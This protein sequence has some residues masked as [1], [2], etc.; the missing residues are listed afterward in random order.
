VQVVQFKWV[1]ASAAAVADQRPQ[2]TNRRL[3]I[4]CR[5]N[6]LRFLIDTGA[7]LSILPPNIKKAKELTPISY[8]Y[9]ANNSLIPVFGERI[10]ELNLGLRRPFVWNF[11][12]ADVDRPI[13]GIDFLSHYHL[14][15]DPFSR[16]LT[17]ADT[18]IKI[19]CQFENSSSSYISAIPP[20]HKFF[21]ILKS[22]PK[23][24]QTSDSLFLPPIT[25]N[26]RHHLITNCSPISFRPRRLSPTMLQIAKKEFQLLLQLGIV[27]P[28]SSPWASPLHMAAKSDGSYRAC[29]DYRSLNNQTLPDSYPIPHI[30]DFSSALNGCAIF[31]RIDLVRAYNQ[32][33]VAEE[34]VPKTAIITPFGL[35]EFVRMPLGLRNSSQTFQ[36]F[37][38]NML[39]DLPFVFV[40]LD[41]LLIASKSPSEHEKHLSIVLERL[42]EHGVTIN[43]QKSTFGQTKVKFVGHMVSADGIHPTPEK[44]QAIASYPRP[45]TIRNLRRFTGLLN[46]YHRFI[47]HLAELQ[48]PLTNVYRTSSKKND[49]TPVE[50][51][52]ELNQAFELCKSTLSDSTRLA[53][54][55]SS[56]QLVLNTDASGTSIGA[57]LYKVQKDDSKEPLGFYSSKLTPTQQK[58]STYDRELLAVYS[59]VKYF[60]HFLE[61]RTFT[62]YTDHK[63][64]TFAFNQNPEK[65]T[66]RQF[67]YLDFISQ[68]TTDIRYVQANENLV[69]DA[70]S[71]IEAINST[72][73][74]TFVTSDDLADAQKSDSQLQTL[75]SNAETSLNLQ[76]IPYAGRDIIC[77]VSQSGSKRPFVPLSLRQRIFHQ[78]HDLAHPGVKRTRHLISTRYVWP[79]LQKDVG[80]WTRS[81][82]TCQRSKISR[83]TSAPLSSFFLSPHR[84]HHVHL[85]LIGPLPV[86]EGNRYCLT[87]IDRACR[88]P[89]VVP[90][91][92]MTADTVANAFIST[93]VARFGCPA[94]IT[95]DQ[96]RQFESG[97]FHNLRHALG[98]ER[99]RTTAYHPQSNGLIENFHRTL[100][101]AITTCPDSFH[102]T[103]YLPFILLILRS[104]IST[105]ANVSP[106]EALYGQELRLPGDIFTPNLPRDASEIS[107]RIAHATSVL[108]NLPHHDPNRKSFIP[109]ALHT[110]SHA[111]VRDDRVRKP[112][113]PAYQGPFK[114]LNRTEKTFTLDIRSKPT[115][116]SIDRLKPC[117]NL[118]EICR[119]GQDNA[120]KK[121]P[122]LNAEAPP[123][124][125]LSTSVTSATPCF[126][127]AGRLSK[128][129]VRFGTNTIHYI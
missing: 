82:I 27:R 4:N 107:Q 78:Y 47:P 30:H 110:C 63:P 23:L 18:S 79:N 84:L 127:R 51:T 90:I 59:A 2:T 62:I 10:L 106:A 75:L 86:S 17:D 1:S 100:K 73:S 102:W 83:H 13:L 12:I 129:P 77:D 94:K 3:L 74:L 52:D 118:S 33:P 71:R 117:F 49:P 64:L 53:F 122:V 45:T 60:R 38:D 19:T 40:Y 105:D 115:V 21:T 46:F 61:G 28:S 57:T 68:F 8:L 31:S 98:T 67:R 34:D 56:S 25:S 104:S 103:K 80:E 93:W 37:M 44:V 9:A 114:I 11:L 99:F 35:F 72:P 128:P 26:V 48:A 113:T 101:T 116:V 111:F 36:R 20:D 124:V 70:L 55:D 121:I 65:A 32:I 89:E 95:T 16:S 7:A 125:P 50:W 29:G 81:C 5:N 108:S 14:L 58:Y 123:F 92:D 6:K 112:F 126:T 24:T 97:L 69:A 87:M 41:D 54:P 120:H 88:W 15:I 119:D 66:P 42:Q 76:S 43:L 109:S 22:Y 96:G 85:D 91:P 39:R